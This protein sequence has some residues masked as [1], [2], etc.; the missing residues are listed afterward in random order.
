MNVAQQAVPPLSSE[1]IA[2]FRA[3]VGDKY[4]VTD[5]ADIAPYTKAPPPMVA[6]AESPA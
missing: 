6:E 5:P 4:A 2:K 3:I 1:L